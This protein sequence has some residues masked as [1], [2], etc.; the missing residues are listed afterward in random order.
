MSIDFEM[1]SRM[2]HVVDSPCTRC[3]TVAAALCG[4]VWVCFWWQAVPSSRI[5]FMQVVLVNV[6]EVYL[7]TLRHQVYHI[8][9][10]SADEGRSERV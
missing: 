3:I 4:L 10:P 2:G 9:Y 6:D 5:I 8:C 1:F 7:L